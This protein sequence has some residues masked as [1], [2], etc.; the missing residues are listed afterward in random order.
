MGKASGPLF[1][2]TKKSDKGVDIATDYGTFRVLIFG[3]PG[4]FVNK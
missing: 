4:F 3:F 1:K 2:K